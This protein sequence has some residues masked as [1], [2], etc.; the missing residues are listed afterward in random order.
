MSRAV[1]PRFFKGLS[2]EFLKILALS[3]AVLTFA[4]SRWQPI[5][6]EDVWIYL[7]TGRY[8]LSHH[9]FL[10][11]DV[12][13]WPVYGARWVNT[14]WLYEVLL[15]LV[16][17]GLGLFGV[18]L[19]KN[20]LVLA[21]LYFVDK[22]LR[23]WG[24]SVFERIV[25]VGIVFLGGWPFW[26]ERADLSSLV[27]FSALFC[28]ID[29]S[30]LT[31]WKTSRWLLWIF[32]F[33]FWAN[34]HGEFTFGLFILGFYGCF[35]ALTGQPSARSV[36]I[37]AAL[38]AAATLLNPY[39]PGLYMGILRVSRS[40]VNNIYEWMPPSGL[41]F[42]FFYLSGGLA[43]ISFLIRRTFSLQ[44]A[45]FAF[46]HQRFIHFFMV[47]TF[48]Y[49]ALNW[50]QSR[51][52]EW[53][54]KSLHQY[55]SW[56]L[57]LLS[58]FLFWTSL[59]SAQTVSG[60]IDA[61]STGYIR[62]VCDFIEK[63]DVQGPF[64]NEYKFGAYWLFRFQGHPAEFQD[65]RDGVIDGFTRVIETSAEAHSQPAAWIDFLNRNGFEA[66]V[67]YRPP[68]PTDKQA[69][70]LNRYFPPSGWAMAYQ[71]DLCVLFLKKHSHNER[72]IV[73]LQKQALI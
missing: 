16:V 60:G 41:G 52:R 37:G 9:V 48:P 47:G 42:L 58:I 25:F 10:R 45:V 15:T 33:V 6:W 51:P 28:E 30:F 20:T 72:V 8:M 38:C 73:K 12:F 24:A 68:V 31:N 29:H 59:A 5:Y 55:E 32:L 62:G 61:R 66:A 50:L 64:Y 67:V 21:A 7:G 27:L 1:Q 35:L 71:D 11:A 18:S 69:L 22:R 54:V 57:A 46:R 17:R 26:V 65:G 36:L 44:V 53:I 4:L 40:H 34:L 14:D 2:P 43:L 13:A 70:V 39:G 3:L 56:A 63:N 49:A 23:F 19:L